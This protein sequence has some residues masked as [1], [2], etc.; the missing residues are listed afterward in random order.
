MTFSVKKQFIQLQLLIFCIT[1]ISSCGIYSFTGAS[2]DPN[3]ETV[4]VENFDVLAGNA[5]PNLNQTLTEK[6]KDK[7]ASETRLKLKDVDGDAIFAGEI[8]DYRVAPAASG[9]NDQAMLNRLTIKIRIEYA[10]SVTDENWQQE[11]SEFEDF[12]QN[13][14]LNEVEE[15]LIDNITDRLVDNVFNKAFANW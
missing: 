2:I 11:F 1:I 15:E 13:T 5:A 3:V 12:D 9:A 14:A 6:L 4:T 10:N 8:R 7:F